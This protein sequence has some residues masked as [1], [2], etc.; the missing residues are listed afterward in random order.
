MPV[1]F[2]K[3][4]GIGVEE[5][6]NK[7]LVACRKLNVIRFQNPLITFYGMNRRL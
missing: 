5:R 1:T 7:A 6:N 4:K 2:M 3:N